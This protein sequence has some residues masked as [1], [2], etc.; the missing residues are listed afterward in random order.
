MGFGGFLK[1]VAGAVIVGGATAVGFGLGGGPLTAG[2]LGGAAQTLWSHWG[3]GK[4]WTESLATGA[5]VGVLGGGVGG[6]LGGAESGLIKGGLK[7]TIKGVKDTI[8]AYRVPSSVL[9]M[10]ERREY[11]MVGNVLRPK[12]GTIASGATA[13]YASYWA[14]NRDSGGGAPGGGG[15][16]GPKEIPII[17]IS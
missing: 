8:E 4:G 16:S 3:E 9:K 6:L 7:N 5:A 10:G 11:A 13:G 12:V 14:G 1:S 2:L 15:Q 17:A